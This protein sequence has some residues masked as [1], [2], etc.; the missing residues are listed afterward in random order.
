MLH[1][2]PQ[3]CRVSVYPDDFEPDAG[4]GYHLAGTSDQQF[5]EITDVVRPVGN[6]DGLGIARHERGNQASRKL[7]ISAL[8]NCQAVALRDVAQN[9]DDVLVDPKAQRSPVAA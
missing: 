6:H 8:P 5:A 4:Q 1:S 7:L 9:R 2:I 3:G